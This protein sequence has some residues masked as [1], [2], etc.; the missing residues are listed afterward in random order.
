MDHAIEMVKDKK[1][2]RIALSGRLT[3]NDLE[4]ARDDASSALMAGHCDRLLV[5]AT[6]VTYELSDLE[7][8][9]FTSE[10]RS[11]LPKGTRIALLISPDELSNFRFVENVAQ[12]RAVNLLLFVDTDKA[13]NWLVDN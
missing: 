7:F 4:N 11:R 12:N 6:R 2:V 1:H 10:H 5:D 9:Q 13:V 8:F 3:R